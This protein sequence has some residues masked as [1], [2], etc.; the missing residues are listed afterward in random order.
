MNP[1]SA[2][3][4]YRIEEIKKRIQNGEKIGQYSKEYEKKWNVVRR[5]I[6]KYKR[7]ANYILNTEL[8]KEQAMM[9]CLLEEDVRT[10]MKK[11]VKCNLE[12][13]AILSSVAG[14]TVECEEEEETSDG[15]KKKKKRNSRPG[16]RVIAIDKLF[17]VRGKYNKRPKKNEKPKGNKGNNTSL[18][19]LSDEDK[20]LIQNT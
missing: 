16:E 12:L 11:G 18:D 20:E 3:I 8:N 7:Y 17:K 14:G 13:E 5:T 19:D 4:R 9:E 2:E 15:K 6:S 1:E 10:K